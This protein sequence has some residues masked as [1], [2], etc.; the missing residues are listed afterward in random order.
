M[1][2]W[3]SLQPLVEAWGPN[4]PPPPP[5]TPGAASGWPGPSGKDPRGSQSGEG[6][7]PYPVADL[8]GMSWSPVWAHGESGGAGR[9]VR[10]PVQQDARAASG[11]YDWPSLAH[12]S[13]FPLLPTVTT[14]S[15]LKANPNQGRFEAKSWLLWRLYLR[16]L[17]PPP[18]GSFPCAVLL[19]VPQSE[20]SAMPE[21]SEDPNGSPPFLCP[22]MLTILL[23]WDQNIRKFRS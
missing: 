9:M 15:R 5:Q 17:Q 2:I 6:G 7:A 3:G 14:I 16:S 12:S 21:W 11:T 22:P 8:Q 18:R 23:I 10:I 4:A 1:W 19:W 20:W 13:L